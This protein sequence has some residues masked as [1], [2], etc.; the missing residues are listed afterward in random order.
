M[1]SRFNSSLGSC[2]GRRAF[3]GR[4]SPPPV[5]DY[6]KL[7][8]VA[9]RSSRRRRRVAFVVTTVVE[10]KDAGTPNLDGRD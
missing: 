6:Y 2:P 10:D 7:V 8:S 9:G 5:H 1:H 4:Q 3:P